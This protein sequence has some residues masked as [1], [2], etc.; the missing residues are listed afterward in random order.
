MKMLAWQGGWVL[1]GAGV[2]SFCRFHGLWRSH[3]Y[4]FFFN[5]LGLNY[6][7]LTNSIL[8]CMLFA[9]ARS[10]PCFWLNRKISL[11][12]RNWIWQSNWYMNNQIK[13]A[14]FSFFLFSLAFPHQELVKPMGIYIIELILFYVSFQ[15]L[16]SEN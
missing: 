6:R 5:T 7:G 2:W 10:C 12:F 8:S 1:R 15:N 3:I 14:Y 16:M 11:C 9:L 13:A 4:I